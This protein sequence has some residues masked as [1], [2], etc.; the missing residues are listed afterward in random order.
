MYNIVDVHNIHK[1]ILFF[2]LSIT[3]RDTKQIFNLI[4]SESGF[5]INPH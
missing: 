3:V 1:L 4:P 2:K 5:K